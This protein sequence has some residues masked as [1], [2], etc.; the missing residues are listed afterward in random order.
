MFKYRD[1][2]FANKFGSGQFL[3]DLCNNF[4]GHSVPFSSSI[5]LDS[6]SSLCS[7]ESK[8]YEITAWTTEI[9]PPSIVAATVSMLG[10][11]DLKN[12]KTSKQEKMKGTRNARTNRIH[13]L[14]FLRLSTTDSF[15][16]SSY[17]FQLTFVLSKSLIRLFH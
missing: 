12:I 4:C 10:S 7:V 6:L 2:D 14:C 3:E 17:V 9:N 1:N 16:L 15:Q 8:K 5:R 13:N 11:M